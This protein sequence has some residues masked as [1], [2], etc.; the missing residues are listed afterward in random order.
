MRQ[1]KKKKKNAHPPP[2][3]PSYIKLDFS[4]LLF[5]YLYCIMF[6]TPPEGVWQFVSP[7][8]AGR[9]APL[10]SQSNHFTNAF[11]DLPWLSSKGTQRT[12]IACCLL[13]AFSV[14]QFS[15]S[16]PSTKL[17]F[18]P[19]DTS[20]QSKASRAALSKACWLHHK[21]DTNTGKLQFS[22]ETHNEPIK[23]G[24]CLNLFPNIPKHLLLLI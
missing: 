8:I 19:T 4:F 3:V 23:G 18:P 13:P 24:A 14:L 16:S 12:I 17:Y 1:S 11:S 7:A 22:I 2:R 5:Y 21:V 10:S 9:F 15:L 6:I 20:K